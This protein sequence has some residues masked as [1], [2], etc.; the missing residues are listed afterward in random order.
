MTPTIDR[1]FRRSQCDCCSGETII[2]GIELD[3]GT[4]LDNHVT[5]VQV[6]DGTP[7]TINVLPDPHGPETTEYDVFG[8]GELIEVT[9]TMLQEL[10]DDGKLEI[11]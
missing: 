3:D 8:D 2:H 9:P 1:E 7:F 11:K 6:D 5:E 10:Y 4:Y